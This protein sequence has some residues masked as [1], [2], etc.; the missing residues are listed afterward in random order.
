MHL[1]AD[2]LT[3]FTTTLPNELVPADSRQ[4]PSLK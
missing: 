2:D 4:E 3:D 1:D